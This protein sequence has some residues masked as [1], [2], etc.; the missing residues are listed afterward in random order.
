MY[1]Y[2]YIHAYIRVDNVLVCGGSA[3][4]SEPGRRP[5]VGGHERLATYMCIY[6]YIYVYMFIF[7]FMYVFI[8]IFIC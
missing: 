4:P 5:G 8:Y 1:I 6:T 2:I 7:I 3:G